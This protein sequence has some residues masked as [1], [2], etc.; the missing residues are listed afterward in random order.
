VK[1]VS[2]HAGFSYGAD[3]IQV[4]ALEDIGIMRML[5]GMT[6][7]VPADSEQAAWMA[8]Q[9]ADIP[10]PV[11]IRLG[12]EKT[13]ILSTRKGDALEKFEQPEIGKAQML[14]QGNKLTIIACGYMVVQALEV[15]NRLAAELDIQ[16]QVL[17]M[18]TIKPLDHEAILQA[19][20]RT[21]KIVTIEEHQKMGGLG[22]A[23]AE[24]LTQTNLPVQLRLIGVND[25][26]GDTA[27]TTAE[28]WDK[29]GLSVD[30][31][32]QDIKKFLQR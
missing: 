18:H 13:Q 31:I 16:A 9:A 2:S 10:G 24:Y 4:Q 12:R 26:F 32:L 1:I 22:A 11:Y 21:S 23:V 15:A 3:G 8:E 5:P 27:K 20:I 7:L 6:V 28:L 29:Y 30:K 25:T 19:A 17:N 14:R